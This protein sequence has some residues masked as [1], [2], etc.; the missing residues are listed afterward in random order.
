M[1]YITKFPKVKHVERIMS[2]KS[3]NILDESVP[4]INVPKL[5]PKKNIL[6]KKSRVSIGKYTRVV[7]Q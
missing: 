6:P 5:K 4:Y 2:V 1:K 7:G 3:C